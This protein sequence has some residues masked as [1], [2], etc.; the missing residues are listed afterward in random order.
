MVYLRN[1][2]FPVG[3]YN[4][5]KDKK[6]GPYKIIKKIND[7]AYVFYLPADMAISFT[8]NVVDVFDYF[9]PNEPIYPEHNSRSS[10]FEV[11]G[12]DV[13]Q[14]A[15]AFLEQRDDYKLAHK[16]GKQNPKRH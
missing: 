4:K 12:T 9:P 15:H 16:L 3:I 13:E 11:G 7:N 8:F 6:Y 2:R 14:I 1:G 5:L 10:S